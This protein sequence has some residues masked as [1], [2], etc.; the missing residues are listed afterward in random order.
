MSLFPDYLNK[1][2]EARIE[3]QEEDPEFVFEKYFNALCN[4]QSNY[5]FL[6]FLYS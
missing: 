1:K 6:Y 3:I 2:W 4:F 5:N